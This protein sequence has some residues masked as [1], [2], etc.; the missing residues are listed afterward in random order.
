MMG[1]RESRLDRVS[2]YRRRKKA[3]GQRAAE[4]LK[5]LGLRMDNGGLRK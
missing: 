3:G 4:M 1:G 2:P 5:A